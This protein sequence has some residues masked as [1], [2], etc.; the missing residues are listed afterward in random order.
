MRLGD[1]GRF[2]APR[3][4]VRRIGFDVERVAGR[5]VVHA[6]APRETAG[7]PG[8]A[9][10]IRANA[11]ART[12]APTA[13]HPRSMEI[14]RASGAPGSRL[15][16]CTVSTP[17]PCSAQ[18]PPG[19]ASARQAEGSAEAAVHPL[20]EVE[21]LAALLPVRLLLSRVGEHAFVQLDANVPVVDSRQL[22]RDF[23]G[24][25]GGCGLRARR[26][27]VRR[28]AAHPAH[29]FEDARPPIRC[30]GRKFRFFDHRLGL[31][32]C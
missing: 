27:E 21:I 8:G 23:I 6:P 10:V 4:P 25:V 20:G 22:E 30:A 16:I 7:R 24:V 5:A 15:A 18:T 19:S 26:E 11:R 17:F 12:P 1:A 28:P 29:R 2:D 14:C 32:S 31:P 13:A 3:D 9:R